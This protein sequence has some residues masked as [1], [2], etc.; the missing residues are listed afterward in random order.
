MRD[1]GQ[2]SLEQAFARAKARIDAAVAADDNGRAIEIAA[3]ADTG[4]YWPDEIS[5]QRRLFAQYAASLI[6]QRS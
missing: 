4:G 5:H 6:A 2:I 3:T 1:A